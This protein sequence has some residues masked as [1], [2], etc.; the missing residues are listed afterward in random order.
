LA[1]V[2]RT[3]SKWNF[4][5]SPVSGDDSFSGMAYIDGVKWTAGVGKIVGQ[6]VTLK[7][8]GPLNVIAQ[9]S[10]VPNTATITDLQAED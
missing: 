6:D 8:T 2:V 4:F 7:G 5:A 1:A 3:P 9:T 10:P